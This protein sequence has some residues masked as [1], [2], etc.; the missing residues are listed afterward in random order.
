MNGLLK[1]IEALEAYAG[2]GPDPYLGGDRET[3]VRHL[4]DLAE[5][6]QGKPAPSIETQ[7][8][9]ERTVRAGLAAVEGVNDPRERAR[10]FWSTVAE[11]L[12]ECTRGR[13]A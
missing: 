3:L 2:S 12:R 6:L 13:A 11:K 7:S 5:R 1:R 8:P 4:S 10:R 9:A